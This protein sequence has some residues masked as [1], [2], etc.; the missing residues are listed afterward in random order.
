MGKGFD[1]FT[2]A[3]KKGAIFLVLFVAARTW[4]DEAWIGAIMTGR[5]SQLRLCA[6]CLG[7][8]VLM[9]VF[10]GAGSCKRKVGDEKQSKADEP[11][12]PEPPGKC[13]NENVTGKCRLHT[14][15]KQNKEYTPGP[16][17]TVKVRVDHEIL[18][19]DRSIIVTSGYWRV[20]D[21]D[22]I[23]LVE[24]YEDA[25]DVPCEAYVVW[26]PCNPMATTVG[27]ELDP[28]PFAKRE[29]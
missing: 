2:S 7:M 13:R 11:P 27:M 16:T 9:L 1:S 24:Y 8:A 25:G 23:K 6:S 28:P 20:K 26:P 3:L 22:V 15:Q 29:E 5:S 17:G 4:Y 18:M 19:E 12:E 14:V 10:C 21:E